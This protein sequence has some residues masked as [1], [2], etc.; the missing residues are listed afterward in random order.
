M[1][2]EEFVSE[3][4]QRFPKQSPHEYMF[5]FTVGK[6]YY[7]VWHSRNGIEVA[8]IYAFVDVG[9]GD[10]YKPA[11]CNAPAKHVRGNIHD[12]A[13]RISACDKHGIKYLR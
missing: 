1:T 7:K 3:L 6:R 11:S 5:M 9:T 8:S 4:N 2:I 10:I 13:S 12:D